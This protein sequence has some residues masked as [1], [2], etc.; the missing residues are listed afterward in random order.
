M[1]SHPEPPARMTFLWNPHQVRLYMVPHIQ[2]QH[3]RS[4]LA[5]CFRNRNQLSG[6]YLHSRTLFFSAKGDA[7]LVFTGWYLIPY[8]RFFDAYPVAL[9]VHINPRPDR[10]LDLEHAGLRQCRWR[11]WHCR[12]Y[13]LAGGASIC[14]GNG[15]FRQFYLNPPQSC[16]A[17]RKQFLIGNIDGEWGGIDEKRKILHGCARVGSCNE[18]PFGSVRGNQMPFVQKRQ[19]GSG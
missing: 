5:K 12:N 2:N 1:F 3:L 4:I 6:L 13:R 15:R 7:D 9:I 18:L 17:A 14:R 10:R 8:K 19:C 16:R 11:G